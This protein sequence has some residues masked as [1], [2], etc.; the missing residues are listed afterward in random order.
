MR[1]RAWWVQRTRSRPDLALWLHEVL[2]GLNIEAAHLLGHSYGGFIAMNFA[3]LYPTFVRRLALLAPL[4]CLA[5]P[6]GSLTLRRM[7][8]IW[9]PHHAV[10]EHYVR[11][12]SF[13]GD[14]GSPILD[15]MMEASFRCTRRFLALGTTPVVFTKMELAGCD[16]P[17]LVM[18]GD[19]E[20]LYKPDAAFAAGGVPAL[21]RDGVHPCVQPRNRDGP[22]GVGE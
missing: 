21:C 8:P 13:R 20:T 7:A 3:L 19:H 1:A 10:L 2:Q 6:N 14:L 16:R 12:L 18:V 5:R 9:L 11:W 22:A 15:K 4:S 17:T